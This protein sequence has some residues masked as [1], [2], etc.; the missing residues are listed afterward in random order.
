MKPVAKTIDEI[1]AQGFKRGELLASWMDITTGAAFTVL[2]LEVQTT[3]KKNRTYQEFENTRYELNSH[4]DNI[5]A[6][7]TF[8]AGVH[9]GIAKAVRQRLSLTQHQL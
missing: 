1:R 4:P 6:W 3:E 9:E 2:C 7:F 5:R 8:D